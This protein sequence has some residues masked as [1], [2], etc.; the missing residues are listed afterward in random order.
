[1]NLLEGVR[2]ALE[3]IRVQKLKSFFAVLGVI[4]AVTFLLTVVT[5]LEG[6]DRYMR[7]DFGRRVYGLNTV[8]VRRT[9]SILLEPPSAELRRQWQ[10]RPTLRLEDADAIRRQ[11]RT[12]AIVAVESDMMGNV[13]GDDGTELANV[14]IMAASAEMFQIRDMRVETGRI[15]GPAEDRIGAPVAVLG[16]E[17][18]QL[19]F[20][21]RDPIG[22]TVRVQG[23]PFRVIGVLERQGTLFGMS[24]DNRLIAPARSPL[25]RLL[26]PRGVVDNIAV[27]A[28]SPAEMEQVRVELESI[29]RIRHG[30]RPGDP[31]SFELETA[32]D[33]MAF[34]ARISQILFIAFPGLVSIA[35]IVGGMVIMNIMLVSVTERTRE[36]GVRKAIG[37]RRRDI[38]VQ[39]LI[40]SAT[41]SGLG[42]LIGIL[43][44]IVGGH[45]VSAVSPLPAAISPLWMFVGAALG[46]GVGVIAGLYPAAR[47]ARMNPIAALRHE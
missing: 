43:A 12:P 4:I 20:G 41:L 14:W 30:L 27:R 36:I 33:S 23:E 2:L 8:T 7:E 10:R 25:A 29:L 13:V 22:R 6:V 31:N 37:A 45:I 26:N 9:P 16:H 15:F 44:G 21:A 28:R 42:A 35:L 17:T 46:V 39:V 11:L 18:A 38:H 47:A 5:V 40:E 19:L 34:W 1:M 32:E 24:M 3:Q